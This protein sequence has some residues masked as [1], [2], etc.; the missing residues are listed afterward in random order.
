[1][2]KY[3]PV[4][5]PT[6]SHYYVTLERQQTET[7]MF[8]LTSSNAY[9]PSLVKSK[10][11]IDQFPRPFSQVLEIR[12]VL[13]KRTLKRE[14]KILVLFKGQELRCSIWAM[15]TIEYYTTEGR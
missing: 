12:H 7:L 1:M 9:V 11:I 2:P 4:V 14:D 13:K 6:P 8:L 3:R 5:S 10:K 15:L